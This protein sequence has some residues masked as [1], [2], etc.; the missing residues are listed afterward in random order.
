MLQK[1]PQN[2]KHQHQHEP[3]AGVC[4]YPDT[5]QVLLLHGS[6]CGEK[7]IYAKIKPQEILEVVKIIQEKLPAAV[8]DNDE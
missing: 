2:R 5:E 8:K 1:S 3:K 6:H 4:V 7:L